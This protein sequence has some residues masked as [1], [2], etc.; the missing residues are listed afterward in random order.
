MRQKYKYWLREW[1]WGNE[2]VPQQ[3]YNKREARIV[4]WFRKKKGT[5]LLVREMTE[6]EVSVVGTEKRTSPDSQSEMRV[7][8]WP[9]EMFQVARTH[10][11]PRWLW[12]CDLGWAQNLRGFL[13]F[14]TNS[15]IA[16]IWKPPS[17]LWGVLSKMRFA[18][19]SSRLG[20]PLVTFFHTVWT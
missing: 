10:G 13:S 12:S 16:V 17:L 2:L 1:R 18:V 15:N 19:W 3:M 7:H 20:K 9:L 4:G 11:K 6:F 14:Y 8:S 5:G